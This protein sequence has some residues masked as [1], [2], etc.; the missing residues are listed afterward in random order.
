MLTGCDASILAVVFRILDRFLASLAVLAVRS[1]R[2]LELERESVQVVEEVG[3][4]LV[5]VACH[6][7][8]EQQPT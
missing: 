5:D 3:V 4:E 7:A 1:G 6:E 8:A 2:F